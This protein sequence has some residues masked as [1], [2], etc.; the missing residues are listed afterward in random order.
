MPA[1]SKELKY[2]EDNPIEL[3]PELTEQELDVLKKRQLAFDKLLKEEN[4]AKYKI[5]VLFA[6]TRRAHGHSAGALSIWESG[7]KLHGGGDTKMYWCP[8][9]EL[10]VSDCTGIIPD[11]S[12]GYGH[13]VCP[14]CK[15]VW[16]GEQVFGEIFYRL[17]AEKWSTVLLR[18][19]IRLEHNADIYLKWPRTDL[20]VASGLE[21]AKQMMGEKLYATRKDRVVSIYPLRNIVKDVSG[22]ADLQSRFRAFITS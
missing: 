6:H 13:L 1:I 18:H 3:A 8:G 7:T 16:Q 17:D 21:Q 22:G 9:K 4:K 14:D 2:G 15:H 10:K 12:N 19:Y 11:A 5:E 20:R